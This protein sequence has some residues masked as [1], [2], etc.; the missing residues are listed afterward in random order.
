MWFD[1]R[2]ALAELERDRPSTATHATSAT[3]PVSRLAGVASVAGAAGARPPESRIAPRIWANGMHPDAA[4]LAEALRLRG[5]TTYGSAASALGWTATR[6]WQAEARLRAAG[7]VRF[8]ELGR[9][10]LEMDGGRK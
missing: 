9:A 6:A 10:A 8:D 4:T 2:K 3:N 1:A 7:L 5:P